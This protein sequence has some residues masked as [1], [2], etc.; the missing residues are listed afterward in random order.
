MTSYHIGNAVQNDHKT[1]IEKHWH[2]SSSETVTI[3]YLK[4]GTYRKKSDT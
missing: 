3:L 4:L 2:T 1:G